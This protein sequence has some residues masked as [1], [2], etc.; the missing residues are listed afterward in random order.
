MYLKTHPK[1]GNSKYINQNE[2]SKAQRLT[3]EEIY[4]GTIELT[5]QRK[6]RLE[7]HQTFPRST[8]KRSNQGGRRPSYEKNIIPIYMKVY[9]FSEGIYSR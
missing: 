3:L 9:P 4:E 1:R 2:H 6:I 5:I 7:I 8:E